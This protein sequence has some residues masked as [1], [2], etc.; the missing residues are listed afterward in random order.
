MVKR[1]AV[2]GAGNGGIN[3]AA[4]LSDRGF[5]VRLFE[6][7]KFRENLEEIDKKKGIL[8][9]EPGHEPKFVP[10]YLATTDIQAAISDAEIIMLTIPGFAVE[11]FCEL[12]A[13]IVE[14]NQLIFFNGAASMGCVRFA[15]KA[16]ELGYTKDFM[17][18]ETNS[19]TY[20]AR[21]SASTASAELLLRVKKIF[22]SSY[23]AKRITEI[24]PL[25]KEIYDCCVP[26]RD[27][28][29]TTLENGNPEVHPGP[30]LMNAGRID[31][32]KGEFYFY[33]E[34]I[35]EHTLNILHGVEKERMEIGKAFGLSLE[36]AITS[37]SNRGYFDKTI[38]NDLQYL[39][40]TSPVYSVLKGPASVHGRYFVED[41]SDGLVL[42]S[43]LGKLANIP[44]PVIDAVITL[45]SQ[46]IGQD[47]QQEGLT[48]KKVGLSATNVSELL[49][50][51]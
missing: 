44:T 24:L 21:A 19:L 41:I 46:L 18:A 1:V 7:P 49:N 6:L 2:L 40:N 33:K 4:D 28:L 27:V 37:R 22:V 29:H 31:Y 42:W 25:V 36:D 23:P 51:V 14:P 50:M 16:K 12:L 45:G 34:G 43:D 39:F 5:E 32:S 8:L 30:C 10:L 17:L 47:F 3:A 48:L 20:G 38:S 9:E 15:K 26:A 35:T 13:P 11:S